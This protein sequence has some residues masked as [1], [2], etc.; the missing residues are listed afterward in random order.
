M[1]LGMFTLARPFIANAGYDYTPVRALEYE[2]TGEILDHE[3]EHGAQ[4]NVLGVMFLPSYLADWAARGFVYD[5][6]SFERDARE[7]AAGGH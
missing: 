2:S 5:D 7:A 3:D 1:R 4:Y 6:I